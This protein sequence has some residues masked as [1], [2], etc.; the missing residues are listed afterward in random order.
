MDKVQKYN[1]FNTAFITEDIQ[2]KDVMMVMTATPQQ[3]LQKWI[4]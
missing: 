3:E 1:S 2:K 4:Q